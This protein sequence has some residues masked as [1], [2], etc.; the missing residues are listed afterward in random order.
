MWS[1]W[2]F[3]GIFHVILTGL[4]IGTELEMP[5]LQNPPCVAHC[6]GNQWL[7]TSFTTS[8]ERKVNHSKSLLKWWSFNFRHL[9]GFATWPSERPDVQFFHQKKMRK[10]SPGN[11]L[12]S[13]GL[14]VPRHLWRE[15]LFIMGWENFSQ[16]QC[17]RNLATIGRPGISHSFF[18]GRTPNKNSN[19]KSLRI[20]TEIHGRKSKQHR[21]TYCEWKKS[22]P[23]WQPLYNYETL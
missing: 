9:A 10:K 23:S 11:Q 19:K 6:P 7:S 8:K 13:P 17:T 4:S 16:E 15:V 20:V 14:A 12:D 21:S 1:S 3:H 2:D 18:T 22:W 5:S